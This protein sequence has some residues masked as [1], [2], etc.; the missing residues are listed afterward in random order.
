MEEDLIRVTPD[1]IK[2]K[3]IL[4]MAEIT[5]EM[6]KTI[7]ENKFPSNAIKEYYEI[8]RELI[9]AL[10]LLDG[11]KTYGEGAHKRVIDYLEKNYKQFLDY[12]ISTINE[13]RIIRNRI[14]Y[15]GFFVQEDYINRKKEVIEAIIN[16][17]REIIKNRL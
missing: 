12:E 14:S 11:Y 10:L 3:S 13:L 4:K 9:S 15:D 2:A 17:L 8:I 1:K 16:K 6:V 7:D 5:L